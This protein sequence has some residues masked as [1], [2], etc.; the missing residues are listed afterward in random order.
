MPESNGK[1][2]FSEKIFL[3]IVSVITLGLIVGVVLLYLRSERMQAEYINVSNELAKKDT[4]TRVLLDSNKVA[5]ERYAMISEDL[6]KEKNINGQLK[7]YIKKQDGK[8][9][10]LISHVEKVELENQVLIGKLKQDS[11]GETFV[12]VDTSLSY[13]YINAR[14]WFERP[15]IEIVDLILIDSSLVSIYNTDKGFY[16]GLIA[17]TNPFIY[18]V[19]AEFNFELPDAK[20]DFSL[21][22]KE[23]LTMIGISAGAGAVLGVIIYNAVKNWIK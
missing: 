16:K 6:M 5:H 17:H 13:Y 2:T 4:L 3:L 12:E 22:S 14:A 18:D 9:K 11:L 10:V 20:T 7:N 23:T 21:F 8:L 15:R 19:N 1:N